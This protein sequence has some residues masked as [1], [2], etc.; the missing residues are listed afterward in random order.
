MQDLLYELKSVSLSTSLT[1]Y[2]RILT[3]A[4]KYGMQ[5]EVSKCFKYMPG[6]L[7]V[8]LDFNALE[9]R[10]DALVTRD[11]AKLLVYTKGY[12]S[13]AYACY[14]YWPEK[15]PDVVLSTEGKP[16]RTFAVVSDGQTHYLKEGDEVELPDGSIKRIEDLCDHPGYCP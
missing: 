4:A 8:G 5:D 2:E 1:E 16:F 12:D 6:W 3:I 9:A 14:H 7:L 15:F 10:V 13:H 11:Q